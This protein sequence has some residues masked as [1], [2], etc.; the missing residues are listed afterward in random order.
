VDGPRL[1]H[2]SVTCADLDRSIA[3]YRDVLGLPL[4]GRGDADEPELSVLTGLPGTRLRWAELDLGGGRVLELVEYLHPRGRELRP[5]V[6]DAGA[7]HLALAVEDIEAAYARLV[8]AG[9][10]VRS[11]PVRLTEEGD[12][13]GVRIL[14]VSDPDGA[15]VELVER[16]RVIRL[17]E[18]EP[19]AEPADRP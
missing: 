6:H 17:P 11:A 8:A 15:T 2:V 13:N 19:T 16:P 10:R 4:L 14:Y 5:S 7:G 3:F 18:A 9:A 1:D 12:W